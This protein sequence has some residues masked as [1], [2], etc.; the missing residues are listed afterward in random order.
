MSIVTLNKGAQITKPS[1]Y[2]DH[3]AFDDFVGASGGVF[4]IASAT[5]DGSQGSA[6]KLAA[7]HRVETLRMPIFR[8]TAGESFAAATRVK[9][10]FDA[11]DSTVQ[12]MMFG[13]SGALTPAERIGF[14]LAAATNSTFVVTCSHDDGTNPDNDVAL[15]VAELPGGSEFDYT[16]W[17]EYA[18]AVDVDD[19]GRCVVKYFID[20][21]LVKTIVTDSVADWDALGLM[22]AQNN[23][24]GGSLHFQFVDWI[25]V[26]SSIRP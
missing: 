4:T 25:S 1:D 23:L 16:A 15:G 21:T 10:D 22:W 11:N 19:S 2:F 7:T 24:T 14:S 18:V 12:N 6:L 9:I 20:K 3:S 26:G 13:T 17:H 8:P 5:L